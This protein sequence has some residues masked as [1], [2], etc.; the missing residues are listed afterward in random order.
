MQ[1]TPKFVETKSE[2]EKLSY[3]VK[4]RIPADVARGLDGRLKAGMTA[5][6]FVRTDPAR[7]GHRSSPGNRDRGGRPRLGRTSRRLSTSS[8]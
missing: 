2:R 7:P 3:R 1:F 6:G 4:L 8:G 5:D